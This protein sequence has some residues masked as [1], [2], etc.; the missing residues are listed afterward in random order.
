MPLQTLASHA[1]DVQPVPPQPPTV[2]P[3]PL[4]HS[5]I[6]TNVSVPVPT[7]SLEIPPPT[8][9]MP[10]TLIVPLAPAQHLP[11]APPVK[12]VPTISLTP[13]MAVS[14]PVPVIHTKTT[15][16]KPVPSVPVPARLAFKQPPPVNLVLPDIIYPLPNVWLAMLNVLIVPE[17]WILNVSP[18][19]LDI[20]CNQHQQILPVAPL[21][22]MVTTAISYSKNVQPVSVLAPPVKGVPN[23]IV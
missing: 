20:Y 14:L 19:P 22:L 16:H 5:Y 23:P 3:V 18:V 6:K 17:P 11:A 21:V 12:L 2:S 9:V 8:P 15:Q 1:W 13:P 10:A 7:V 4:A